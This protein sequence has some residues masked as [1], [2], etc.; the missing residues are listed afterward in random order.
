LDKSFGTLGLLYSGAGECGGLF[1][2]PFAMSPTSSGGG[3]PCS[4]AATS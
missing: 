4:T 2:N 1:F 3:K